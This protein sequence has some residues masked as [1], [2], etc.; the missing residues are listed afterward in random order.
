MSGTG[1]VIGGT[2]AVATALQVEAAAFPGHG[3]HHWALNV[4]SLTL[5]G[6]GSYLWNLTDTGGAA[7]LGYDQIVVGGSFRSVVYIGALS[8][9]RYDCIE[10]LR[11]ERLRGG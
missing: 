11:A 5:N 3:H 7:G 6:G 4:G 10:A 1:A 8:G 9:N 2:D